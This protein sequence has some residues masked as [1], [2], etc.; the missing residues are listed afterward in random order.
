VEL[1]TCTSGMLSARV[2]A[3]MG[4]EPPSRF[5]L[6]FI[7]KLQVFTGLYVFSE[8]AERI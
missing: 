5:R 7:G 1:Y 4:Y 6:V 3:E 2:R 8:M